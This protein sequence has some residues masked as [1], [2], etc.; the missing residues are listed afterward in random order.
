LLII[1]VNSGG[2]RDVVG[3]NVSAHSDVPN[4][5]PLSDVA[6][7]SDE[8]VDGTSDVVVDVEVDGSSDVVEDVD[9]L[10]DADVDVDVEVDVDDDVEVEVDVKGAEVDETPV[11]AL[12]V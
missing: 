11:G 2:G 3:G 9:E 8:L 7:T 5:S 6:G 4:P 12:G 10:V 1:V